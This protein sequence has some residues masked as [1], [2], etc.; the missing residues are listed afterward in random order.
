MV[1]KQQT[2]K[3]QVRPLSIVK[4]REKVRLVSIEAGRGLNSRLVSMGL[5]PNIEIT[6][7][8]NSH[9]GPFV[10]SVKGYKMMLGRGMA[11]KIMVK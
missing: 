6:V 9:P 2:E 5:V 1:E 7:L 11:Q 3:K 8:N 10:I 4:E